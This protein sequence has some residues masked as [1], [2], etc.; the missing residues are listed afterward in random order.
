MSRDSQTFFALGALFCGIVVTPCPPAYP[1]AKGRVTPGSPFIM[2][3]DSHRSRGS[4]TDSG[5]EAFFFHAAPPLPAGNPT[6][7]DAQGKRSVARRLSSGL[8][9]QRPEA[10]PVCQDCL[11]W[12]SFECRGIRYTPGEG[13]DGLPGS[14]GAGG[15]AGGG[16][17]AA[18]G[19]GSTVGWLAS[20]A[21]AGAGAGTDAG[22]GAGSSSSVSSR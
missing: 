18:A 12:T 20:G 7:Q 9:I 3:L 5:E 15:G 2:P 16:S 21:R 4:P 13:S 19:G 1:R 10:I 6:R 8:A 22:A 11:R 14:S 17:G